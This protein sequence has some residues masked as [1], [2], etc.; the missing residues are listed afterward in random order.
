[1]DWRI[2][3]SIMLSWRDFEEK[4]K[5]GGKGRPECGMMRR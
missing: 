5:A 1:M 3:F 4:K 2:K